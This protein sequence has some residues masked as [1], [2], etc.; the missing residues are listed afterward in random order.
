MKKLEIPFGRPWIED[1]DR[2]AVMAVLKGH[3]LT[4]GPECAA[5]E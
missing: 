5:F 3:I 2:D 4:H 1:E